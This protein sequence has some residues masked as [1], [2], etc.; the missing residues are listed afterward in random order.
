MKA[1]IRNPVVAEL[2]IRALK[3]TEPLVPVEFENLLLPRADILEGVDYVWEWLIERTGERKDLTSVQRRKAITKLKADARKIRKEF[4]RCLGK[5]RVSIPM[6]RIFSVVVACAVCMLLTTRPGDASIAGQ[7]GDVFRS[8]GEAFED[9]GHEFEK[10]YFGSR[11][12]VSIGERNMVIPTAVDDG[13]VTFNV[14]NM[15]SEYREL[16]IS[17]VSLWRTLRA[18]IAPGKTVKLT[19]YLEPGYY[20]VTVWAQSGPTKFLRNELAVHSGS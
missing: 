6:H 5:V 2:L 13:K 18:T 20:D 14:T 15:G 1:Q 12:D 8:I 16:Q 3:E 10:D 7:A 11:V 17:G 4:V 9:A 19:T